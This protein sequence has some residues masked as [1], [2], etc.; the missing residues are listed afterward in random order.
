ML[1]PIITVTVSTFLAIAGL[2]PAGAQGAQF[3]TLALYRAGSLP[4][5]I[6]IGS[7]GA[8][9]SQGNTTY[10]TGEGPSAS[11]NP[12]SSNR[13]SNQRTGTL[14]VVS[15]AGLAP[16]IGVGTS[17][18]SAGPGSVGSALGGA[19]GG[20]L[21]GAVGG[22]L[23]STLGGALGSNL[24]ASANSGG[25]GGA[26]GSLGSTFLQTMQGQS[27]G[28]VTSIGQAETPLALAGGSG[29]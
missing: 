1:K 14:T 20:A 4:R 16:M 26:T 12:P 2:L 3:D 29:F 11:L 19:V 9:G 6:S 23:G 10:K 15:T 28:P 25:P 24:G 8:S 21:G 5:V 13:T 17:G 7:N 18:A 22:A 27:G